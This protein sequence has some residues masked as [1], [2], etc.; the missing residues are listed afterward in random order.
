MYVFSWL[1][2]RP[3]VRHTAQH[4]SNS[5]AHVP[6]Y[7]L[8][9]ILHTYKGGVRWPGGQVGAN[10]GTGGG[11]FT[12][13]FASHHPGQQGDAAAGA[14]RDGAGK[15]GRRWGGV[16]WPNGQRGARLGNKG[17]CGM[18]ARK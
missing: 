5:S 8:P 6:E 1:V 12:V 9:G 11:G 7:S 2:D 15:A 10:Q 13:F 17:E 3:W 14:A 16:R 4:I 18:A